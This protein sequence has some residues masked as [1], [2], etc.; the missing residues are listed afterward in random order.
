MTDILTLTDK[1]SRADNGKLVTVY[2]GY[3]VRTFSADSLSDTL[4]G[5][6]HAVVYDEEHAAEV[7]VA[8]LLEYKEESYCLECHNTD[9]FC[10]SCEPLPQV[11]WLPVDLISEMLQTLDQ[12]FMYNIKVERKVVMHIDGFELPDDVIF[13]REWDE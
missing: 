1:K 11:T 8:P 13:V 12:N 9:L 6:N 10:N 4:E 7:D 2:D 3:R 5:G